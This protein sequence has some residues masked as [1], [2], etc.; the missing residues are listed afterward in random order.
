[1]LAMRYADHASSERSIAPAPPTTSAPP[2]SL[3]YG[4]TRYQRSTPTTT[5]FARAALPLRPV[6]PGFAV[7][8]LLIAACLALLVHGARPIRPLIRRYRGKCPACG[9]ELAGLADGAPC[10]ECGRSL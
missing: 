10:P 9:Y 2:M 5:A 4:L 3:A 1:M 6:W 8:T 7:N